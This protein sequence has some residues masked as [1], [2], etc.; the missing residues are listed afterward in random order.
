MTNAI[1]SVLL[2]T[3]NIAEQFARG[4]AYA[5]CCPTVRR[6]A[7]AGRADLWRGVSVP[8]RHA[9]YEVGQRSEVDAIYVSTPPFHK[10]THLCLQAGKAVLC[11]K[12]FTINAAEAKAVVEVT[13]ARR[14][15]HGGRM[16]RFSLPCSK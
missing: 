4:L 9:S 12:P 14:L 1:R 16:E 13:R 7:H 15:S 10:I 2:G 5:R 8:T 6:F 11:E 3:G